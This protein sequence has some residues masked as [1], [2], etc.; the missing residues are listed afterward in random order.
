MMPAAGRTRRPTEGIGPMIASARPQSP[1]ATA[2]AADP[3]SLAATHYENFPVGS[4]LLPRRARVHLRRIYAFARTADDLADEARDAAALAAFRASFE[5]EVAAEVAAQGMAAGAARGAGRAGETIPLLVDL[6]ATIRELRLPVSLFLDLLD[7][8]AL[9]LTVRQHDRASLLAY[10]RKS[11]DPVGRLVLRVFGHDEA[12]L[13]ALSDRVCTALQIVNHLQDVG[14]DWRER[15]RVYLPAEDLARRG[16]TLDDLG[17]A[18][19][20]SGL[21]EVVHEWAQAAAAMF[22]DGFALTA[23]VRGRLG[24]ELRAILGGAALVL[25][26]LRRIDYDVLATH[27]RLAKRDKVWIVGRALLSRRRPAEFA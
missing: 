4:L 20:S 21:R 11:A 18:S 9:D 17:A 3:I 13:D 16:V 7:A 23:L 25:R 8:F 24:A 6:A 12:A 19:A 22:R 2:R 26:G 10:C 15:G 5:A 14:P 1:A 27:V